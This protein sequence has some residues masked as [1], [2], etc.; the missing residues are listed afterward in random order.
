MDGREWWMV[1]ASRPGEARVELAFAEGE[2]EARVAVA[3]LRARGLLAEC[4]EL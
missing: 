1:Q 2:T 3:E 4:W